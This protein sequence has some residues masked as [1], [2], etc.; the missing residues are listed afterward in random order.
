M[1]YSLVAVAAIC[2]N[3][4]FG[5]NTSVPMWNNV[6]SNYII[7]NFEQGATYFPYSTG[8]CQASGLVLSTLG[9]KFVCA[10]D[11]MSV[12]LQT[13]D[14]Y[15]CTGDYSETYINSTGYM[16][17]TGFVAYTYG[18]T[19][20]DAN[21]RKKGAFQCNGMDTYAKVTF[22]TQMCSLVN[23]NNG[24]TIYAALDV[25]QNSPASQSYPTGRSLSIWCNSMEARMQYWLTSEYPMCNG[26]MTQETNYAYTTC[27]FIF[28][29]GVNIYGRLDECMMGSSMTTTMS[30]GTTTTMSGGTTTTGSGGESNA[31]LIS[32]SFISFIICV[33]IYLF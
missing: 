27:G 16:G 2:L 30:G 21:R 25:C 18:D 32:F 12:T 10:A 13:Y 26:D 5:L 29:F 11:G 9:Y 7:W 24:A 3:V 22:D 4:A 8:K 31:H 6:T 14:D 33:I 20:M 19:M 23:A 1:L 17:A 28:N 15:S